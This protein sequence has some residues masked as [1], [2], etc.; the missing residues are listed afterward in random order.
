MEIGAECLLLFLLMSTYFVHFKPLRQSGRAQ[1]VCC[2]KV[3]WFGSLRSKWM[4]LGGKDFKQM[5]HTLKNISMAGGCLMT[6]GAVL[7]QICKW[8]PC[9]SFG[10]KAQAL[11]VNWAQLRLVL[12]WNSKDFLV[13]WLWWLWSLSFKARFKQRAFQQKGGCQRVSVCGHWTSGW[14]VIQVPCGQERVGGLL[15]DAINLQSSRD[16]AALWAYDLVM[17][18][19]VTEGFR[20]LVVTALQ[21][22][23]TTA[24]KLGVLG[25]RFFCRHKTNMIWGFGRRSMFKWRFSVV[26]ILSFPKFSSVQPVCDLIGSEDGRRGQRSSGTGGA[27]G[28]SRALGRKHDSWGVTPTRKMEVSVEFIRK[29][30]K[31]T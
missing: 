3:R 27:G 30:Q 15:V 24:S 13:Q 19:D 11:R 14:V 29:D 22:G 6:I 20:D 1:V 2:T 10:W 4:L 12:V 18:E 21:Q 7:P 31:S 28:E 25:F 26:V 8:K 23:A 5:L 16:A 9:R 17:R